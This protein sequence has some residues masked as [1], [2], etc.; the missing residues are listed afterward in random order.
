MAREGGP[1][2]R[3]IEIG[4]ANVSTTVGAVRRNAERVIGRA[5]EMTARGATI[6]ALPEPVLGG[7]PAEDL[8]QWRGFA[9]PQWDALPDVARAT[10]EPPTVFVPGLI[11]DVE[12]RRTLSAGEPGLARLARGA[13]F[14]DNIDRFDAFTLAVEVCEDIW[15]PDGP[16][17]RRTYSGV[18]IA[19]NLSASP[20][21]EDVTTGVVD[22][23]RTQR[24]DVENTTWRGD[25]EAFLRPPPTGGNFFLPGPALA[26]RHAERFVE[27]FS[28]SICTWVQAPLSLHAGTLDPERER[29]LQRPVVQRTEWER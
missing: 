3:L 10:A 7:Y 28:Q 23:D 12:G 25:R 20:F 29:A 19:I 21:R 5:R 18:E 13:P 4:I 9:A 26:A 8:V 17:R 1:P 2:V 11:V 14:G 6:G 27:R 16:M 15:W 24:L 22:L